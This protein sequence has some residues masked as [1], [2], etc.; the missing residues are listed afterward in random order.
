MQS[1]SCEFPVRVPAKLSMEFRKH[2]E[3]LFRAG[4]AGGLTDG[5]LL[6]RFLE[7]RDEVAE[8]AFTALVERHGAMVL[9]VCRQILRDETD[10]EDAAQ[11][12]FLVLAQGRVCWPPRVGRVLAARSGSSGC[13]KSAHSRH[14]AVRARAAR[15]RD[16]ARRCCRR[17]GSGSD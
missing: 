11:A 6:E 13:G 7:R 8:A 16:E 14:P 15:R 4:T 12:T 9:R 1:A 3:T 17:P 10:A 2:I 5:L